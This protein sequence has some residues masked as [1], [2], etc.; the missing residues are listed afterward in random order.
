VASYIR[1][2]KFLATLGG[3][4]VAW[5]LVARAQ[6]PERMRRIGVLTPAAASDLDGQAR[7]AAFRQRL[8]Q[9][10]WTDGSNVRIEVRWSA[11]NVDEIRKYAAEVVALA[12]DVILCTGSATLAP[13]LQVTRAVPIVFTIVPDPVGAGFVDSLAR[14]GGNATGFTWFE[15]ATSAKW[16]ELLKQIAPSV[17][18]VAVIRDPAIAAGIGQWGAIQTAAPSFGVEVSPVN[19][20]DASEIERAVTA[21]ARSSNGGLISTASALAVV[22]RDLIITLAAR[23]K[24]PAVYHRRLFVTDGGLISY[25]PDLV[26]QYRQAA[27]YIDRILKGEKAADLPV[28]APTK[29]ELVINLKT[30]KALGL[31]VPPSLLARADEVIE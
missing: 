2:R 14:P 26:D 28:Q 3:A 16:L 17:T 11:G 31:E 25:G 24:L 4:A 12:P 23:H 7:I 15:Y 27:G 6:Q 30:A 21:F 19:V 18:R 9:L 10:G 8:Q 20:R 29:Y 22:H 1:R 13:L 5:P